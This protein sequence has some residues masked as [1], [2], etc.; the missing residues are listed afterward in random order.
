MVDIAQFPVAHAHTPFGH[1][2]VTFHNVTSGQKSP[3]ETL[4][5]TGSDREHMRNRYIV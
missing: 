2:E 4:S 3:L 1:Y 5:G